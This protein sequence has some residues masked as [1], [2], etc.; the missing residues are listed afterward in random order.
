MVSSCVRSFGASQTAITN[1]SAFAGA[2][3]D[4]GGRNASADA[5]AGAIP[6]AYPRFRIGLTSIAPVLAVGIFAAQARASPSSLQSS[7]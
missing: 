7:T 1:G 4:G 6:A 5:I 2:T 3:G